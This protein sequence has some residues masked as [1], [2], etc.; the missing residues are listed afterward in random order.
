MPP[1]RRIVLLAILLLA[2]LIMGTHYLFEMDRIAQIKSSIQDKE[3]VL[4][5]KRES[6]RSHQEQVDFYKTA[7]GIE[8]LAR[9][10]YNLVTSGER[11]ILLR[12]PDAHPED[13]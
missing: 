7:E 3:A 6:V 2:L 12:S 13:F 5:E 4:E 9:E 10:R 11:V 8:H 1:L